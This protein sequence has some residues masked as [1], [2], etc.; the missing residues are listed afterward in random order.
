MVPRSAVAIK[1]T[2][3]SSI[4]YLGQQ[5]QYMVPRSAGAIK[6][7]KG[8]SIGYLGSNIRICYLGQQCRVH[9]TVV[10]A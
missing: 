5:Y 3:G 8:S 7:T 2:E 1:G 6:G 9:R 4:G 10:A